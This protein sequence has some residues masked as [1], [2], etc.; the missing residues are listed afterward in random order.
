[1]KRFEIIIA[2]FS[3]I[4]VALKFLH[5]PGAMI[6]T[7]TFFLIYSMFYYIFSFALLNN[8]RVRDIFK[9]EAYKGIN[10]KRIVGAV[11]VGYSLSLVILGICFRLLP[12]SGANIILLIGLSDLF[13]IAVVAI[14]KYVKTRS[15]FYV[16]ILTRIA[17]IGGIGLSLL[18][19]SFMGIK[20]TNTEEQKNE[21]K[22]LVQTKK[23]TRSYTEKAQRTK[24]IKKMYLCSEF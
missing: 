21:I 13:I 22:T 11:G 19:L 16:G 17:I 12:L 9:I 3:V 5:V 18:I 4:A 15:K 1:M 23:I 10:W 14:I 20:F 6:L 24:E 8:I 2:I 7:F